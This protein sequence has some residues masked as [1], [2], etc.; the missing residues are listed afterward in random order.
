[1]GLKSY[2]F[3]GIK[4][5]AT[6][7]GYR[8]EAQS[9]EKGPKSLFHQLQ[10]LHALPP[11]QGTRRLSIWPTACCNQAVCASSDPHH[12]APSH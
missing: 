11:A 3:E 6:G 4:G 10:L 8:E 2:N 5:Q 1:M 9:K 12:L 7:K